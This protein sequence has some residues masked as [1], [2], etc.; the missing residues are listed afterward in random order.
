MVPATQPAPGLPHHG[1]EWLTAI[2]LYAAGAQR[3]LERG[4]PDAAAYALRR[5]VEQIEEA[6]SLRNGA[7]GLEAQAG[8]CSR[9]AS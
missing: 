8:G 1:N 9:Q 6:Q 4:R 7:C 2:R 3:A 5:I